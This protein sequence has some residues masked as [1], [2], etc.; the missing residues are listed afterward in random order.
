MT[1]I[2][3]KQIPEDAI[4]PWKPWWLY[5]FETKEGHFEIVAQDWVTK[6]GQDLGSTV[7]I[8]KEETD[9]SNDYGTL[10]KKVS[11]YFEDNDD[12][13]AYVVKNYGVQ[14]VENK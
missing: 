11:D 7:C 9:D 3:T 5:H 12:A 4:A 8:M 1:K 2:R 6:E 10:Y 13:I 14:P